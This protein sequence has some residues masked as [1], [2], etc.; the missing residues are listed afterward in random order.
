MLREEIEFEPEPVFAST[1]L[2]YGEEDDMVPVERSIE[3]WRRAREDVE[4][5]RLPG[6]GH[7][8]WKARRSRRSTSRGS[9]AG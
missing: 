6:I 7:E 1:L 9:S 8:P 4:V 5:V 2:F 3:V